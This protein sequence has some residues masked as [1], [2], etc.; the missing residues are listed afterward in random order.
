MYKALTKA[1]L[2][3]GLVFSPV[4]F[5]QPAL[6][7]EVI[8]EQLTNYQ[9]L[10]DAAFDDYY[11]AMASVGW[12][13]TNQQAFSEQ[14]GIAQSTLNTL[15]DR[16]NS[17]A[18]DQAVQNAYEDW[19][20]A[21]YALIAI[22]TGV[23]VSQPSPSPEPSPEPAPV[24]PS[25]E[26][27]VVEP[28]QPV[29]PSPQ[30]EPAPEPPSVP[31]PTPEPD[32]VPEPQ[33]T[34]EPEPTSPVEPIEPE[35][36]EPEQPVQPEPVEPE[37]ELDPL[38]TPDPVEPEPSPE[39]TPAPTESTAEEL[40]EEA[41]LILET[42]EKGSPEYLEALQKLFEAAEADDVPLPA[43]IASIP[44]LGP[45]AG[46]ILDVFN[47]LGNIGSDMAPEQRERSEEVIVAAVIAGQIA[48]IASGGAVA[49]MRRNP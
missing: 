31:A 1:A 11:T 48:Q 21:H 40:K 13:I 45:I 6:A 28:V 24:E 4:L 41:L 20:E 23:P 3:S 26:P 42:A 36:V 34:P 19:Y 16:M 18:N 22:V 30:P 44:L 43:E 32:P 5:A 8:V 12:Q 9:A 47:D 38:P 15:I 7:E 46:Q 2:A 37:P 17:N 14:V 49:T 27:E 39:P 35:P 33:P 29:E 25:P 10:I